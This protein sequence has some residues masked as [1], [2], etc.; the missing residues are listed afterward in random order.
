MAWCGETILPFSSNTRQTEPSSPGSRVFKTRYRAVGLYKDKVLVHDV[1]GK[2]S[3]VHTDY[4][5]LASQGFEK[6]LLTHSPDYFVSRYPLTL[7]GKVIRVIGDR[8]YEEVDGALWDFTA[9]VYVK[10]VAKAYVG[11]KAR[12]GE[13]KVVSNDGILSVAPI[14]SRVKGE[15]TMRVKLFTDFKG[16]YFPRL[17]DPNHYYHEGPAAS[18]ITSSLRSRAAG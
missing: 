10:D 4:S 17:E 14:G 5:V 2:G 12:D 9:D 8:H 11:Y 1:A 13:L 15:T 18:S 16:R 7:S 6:L 3:V